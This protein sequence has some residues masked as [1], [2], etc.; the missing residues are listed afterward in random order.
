MRCLRLTPLFVL[1][2]AVLCVGQAQFPDTPA[3]HQCAAW[4]ESFNRGDRD[5]YRSFLQ[6]SFPSRV[7]D[8]DRELRFRQMTGGFDL[9]KV[10]GSTPTTLTALVQE[11]ASDQMGRLT[12][13]VAGAEPHLITKLGVRAIPRPAD[14]PLPRLNQ[15]DLIAS[16]KKE[17]ETEVASDRFAGAVLVAKDGRSILAEAYGLADR[18]GKVPNTLKTRFRIGSMNKMFTAVSILQLAQA[19]KLALNDP[20]GKYLIDYPNKDV[21]AKVMIHHLLTHTGGTG[22]IFGPEFDSHRLELRT[23]Q[24]YVKLYGNRAPE[25][26]PGSQWKYSNYGYVRDHVYTP[27][28][29][30]SSG[31]DPEDQPVSDRSIG[32][33]KMDSSEWKVNTDTLP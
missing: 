28:G 1:V 5:A 32:Y 27:A 14:F 7:A 22:D 29:M 10:E 8:L 17:I 13:E 11:R 24:D 33:T 12:L 30:T 21:A 9:K 25:F 26:D 2:V 20:L 6:K 15:A 18:Q 4:L 31:S 16:A 3:G 23:L 19:G